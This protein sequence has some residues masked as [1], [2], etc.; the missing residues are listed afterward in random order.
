MRQIEQQLAS[1]HAS[2][3]NIANMFKSGLV[4]RENMVYWNAE[5]SAVVRQQVELRERQSQ[6]QRNIDYQENDLSKQILQTASGWAELLDNLTDEEASYPIKRNLILAIVQN[7]VCTEKG[8]FDLNLV[9]SKS[10]EWYPGEE[11]NLRRRV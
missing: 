5:L 8:H 11:S 9:M 4:T 3:V 6:I 7:V 10:I 1:A 2:E